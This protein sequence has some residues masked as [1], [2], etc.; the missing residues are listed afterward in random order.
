MFED[1][2]AA[3]ADPIL[4]LIGL[5]HEDPR[6]GKI[7]LGIGVYRNAEGRTPIMRAVYEAEGRVREAAMTKSYV[8]PEGDPRFCS[9]VETLIFGADHPGSRVASVQTAG[10]AGALRV[11]AGLLAK[12]RPGVKI[13]VPDPT[14]VNHHSIFADAGLRIDTYPYFDEATCGV[15]ID[16][17]LAALSR[18]E[19]G[20][21]VLLHACCHNPTGAG[22]SRED[23]QAICDVM[24]ARGLIAYFDFAYQGFGDGLEE[25]AFA[26]RLFA[27]RMPEMVVAYSCSKNFSIYRERTGAALVM[28]QN[29][30]QAASAKSHMVVVTRIIYSMPPD[31]GA[32]IVRTILED[33]TL[34]ADWRRELTEMHAYLRGNRERL[35]DAFTAATGT[36]RFDFLRGHRGM[37][38]RLGTT[39]EQ[40]ERLRREEG[41]YLVGD[42]RI[43]LAGLGEGLVA[44]FVAAVTKVCMR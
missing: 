43:N 25:D 20:D 12:A 13:H 14:W 27:G 28:A 11:L 41:I 10:G 44:P 40:V 16:E 3:P 33:E 36:D 18:A 24:E 42:G 22:P 37:F 30:T 31:H 8:G 5:F 19:R 39:P 23:W 7:D 38:S 26:V 9:A 35:A 34:A 32:A 29:A 17:M 1:L 4:S 21:V 2:M 15:R 6:P